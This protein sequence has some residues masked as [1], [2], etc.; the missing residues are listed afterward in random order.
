MAMSPEGRWTIVSVRNATLDSK[1]TRRHAVRRM[2]AIEQAPS[3]L[4]RRGTNHAVVVLV[5]RERTG[6]HLDADVILF[7]QLRWYSPRVPAGEASAI[8]EIALLD[9][10]PLGVGDGELGL[11]RPAA[12]DH[13]VRADLA[14]RADQRHV[15][16]TA[17]SCFVAGPSKE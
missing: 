5:D 10:L 15:Q 6:L 9:H 1:G 4:G 13:H 8:L 3:R 14:G 12:V 17:A 7:F 2:Y 16:A 11:R